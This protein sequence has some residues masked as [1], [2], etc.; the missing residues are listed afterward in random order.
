MHMR[1]QIRRDDQD[2]MQE[3]E[4]RQKELAAAKA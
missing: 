3:A 4:E 2:N 1:T